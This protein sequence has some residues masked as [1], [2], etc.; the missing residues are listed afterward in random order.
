M[1]D[2]QI[3]TCTAHSGAQKTHDWVV[4]QLVDLF[5]TTHKVKT[6]H[7]TKIRGRHCGDVDLTVYLV[8]TVGTVSFVLDLLIDHDHFGSTSYQGLLSSLIG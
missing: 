8:N 3:C 4:D 1:G 7:V 5:H 6:Q 2:H